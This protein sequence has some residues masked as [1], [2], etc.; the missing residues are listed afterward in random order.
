LPDTYINAHRAPQDVSSGRMLAPGES[1][2]D[3][4]LD[5]DGADKWLIDE[6][7]LLKADQGKPAR[8]QTEKEE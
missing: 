3:T 6:G 5:L 2:K 1:V 4:E 8:R 7:R